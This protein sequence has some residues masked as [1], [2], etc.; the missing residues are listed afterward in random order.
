MMYGFKDTIGRQDLL[1]LPSEAM[2]INGAYIESL[3]SGYR[4]LYVKGREALSPDI[5]TGEVGIRDGSYR[6]SKRFPAREI[7][8]GYQL[9]A[10]TPQEFISRFRTLN[11][12]LNVEDAELIFLDEPDK[13]I[14]GTPNGYGDIPEG[15]LSIKSEFKIIC[16]DPF[17]YSVEEYEVVPTLE[18]GTVFSVDYNGTYPSYPVLEADFYQTET[19]DDDSGACGIVAFS[20]DRADVLQFGYEPDPSDTA[21]T[22]ERLVSGEITTWTVN[23]VMINE[24][25]NRLI[26]WTTND[27][28]TGKSTYVKAG[29]AINGTIGTS[30]NRAFMALSYG[31]TSNKQWHGP[32]L[33]KSLPA[34]AGNPSVVGAKSWKLHGT[35]RFA[36][37]KDEKTA[38]KEY[39][40]VRIAVL[41]ANNNPIAVVTIYKKAGG[42]NGVI[43]LDVGSKQVKKWTN[44]NLSHYGKYFGFK[45]KSGDKRPCNY[46]VKK[47]GSKFSFN[48]GGKTYSY[49]SESLK[50]TVA[51]KVSLYIA[52]WGD[53]PIVDAMGIYNCQFTSTSVQKTKDTQTWEELTL[54]LEQ[55][56]MFTSNDVLVADCSD[57]SIRILNAYARDEQ[58]GGLHPE[59]GALGNDWESFT[60]VKGENLIGTMYSDWVDPQYKPTF[61]LRYRERF[62]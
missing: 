40:F 62:L 59:Y 19:E 61:K 26:G 39:G 32:T 24:A 18:D 6:K 3:V 53:K 23:Q 15:N 30:N 13:F 31:S 1:Q 4:T 14:V 29:T 9:I 5:V 34:D 7:I 17:F 54:Q 16:D 11:D 21:E 55:P 42:N 60:L 33:M 38:K 43:A 37:S 48:V 28:Y 56:K 57:G 35:M 12:V 36:T 58:N 27:G 20:T 45:K 8:V 46:D 47:D 10:D 49:K 44:V 50:N 2:Q 52:R 41:D 51:R 25:F 22:V